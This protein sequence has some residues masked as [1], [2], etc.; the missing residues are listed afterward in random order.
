MRSFV[1]SAPVLAT[2]LLLVATFADAQ[3]QTPQFQDLF[4]QG[5]AA[6]RTGQVQAAEDAFRKATQIAP[7]FAPAYL[8]MGLAQLKLGKLPEATASIRKALAIDPK[9]VGAH[10]FLGIA[11]YQSNHIHRA[12]EDLQKEIAEAPNNTQAL[13]WLGIVELESGHPEQ[14]TGP[15][16]RAA[17]LNPKD[18]NI[19]D[20]RGQ[21]HMAV[22]KLS[23]AQMYHLDPGSWRV[24]RLNAQID[25]EAE[26]HKQAI[27]EYQAAIRIGPKEADLYEGLGEEYRQVGQL[28]LAQKAF[29]QQLQLT[30][31]NPI[32]MYNLGSVDVD[33]S[34]EKA[35][36]PLLEKVVK[37]YGKPT[38]A[39]YYL[40]RGLAAEGKFDQ[41][42]AELQRAT[43]IP[44]EVQQ[45]AWYEL[46][47][48]YRKM[49]RPTDARAAL[50]KFQQLRQSA[51]KQK[52]QEI[53]D[54]RK[55]NAANG[56]Q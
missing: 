33:R 42:A 56:R 45:R 2:I 39:D 54:W 24:H 27:D 52:A 35:G 16:D 18:L 44:G 55:L 7:N 38:V 30:P 3:E 21:A 4:R 11:E 6:M 41:A 5:A 48:V 19:L 23:Y 36:V 43:S 9:T 1:S 40:G 12:I 53:E 14:A 28:D 25:A 50:L 32:A 8:D 51:D 22:A 13:L 15:L 46:G 10:M 20:Y 37:I 49:D 17:E 31:G 26:Q 29:S 47:Q 34:E